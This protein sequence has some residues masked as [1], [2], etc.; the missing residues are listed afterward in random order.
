M[1]K[2]YKS[3]KFTNDFMFAKVM[4]NK[5]LCKKLL[6]LILGVQIEKIEYPEEQKTI[7]ISTNS[8]RVTLYSYV[9]KIFLNKEDT[10]TLLKICAFR[11][12]LFL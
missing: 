5:K 1:E 6:E 11:I 8:I 4:R 2:E 9:Q 7:D 12:L 10:F 3:L